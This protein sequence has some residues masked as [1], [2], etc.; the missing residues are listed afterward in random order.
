M[1]LALS[2]E[3]PARWPVMEGDYSVGD[4]TSSVAVCTLADAD[5]PGELK[6]AG[7]LARVAIVGTL[8]TENLGVERVVRNVVANPAI[9][10]LVLCGRDSRGHQAGQALLALKA[11]GLDGSLRVVGAAGPRAVLKNVTAEEVAAFR[12]RVTVVDEIGTR[13]VGGIAS[14]V[15]TC[16][17]QPRER[18]LALPPKVRQAKVVQAERQKNSEWVHDPEG[19]FVVL[20]DREGQA[21]VCEHYTEDQ[22]LNEVIRGKHANDIANTAIKRG[23][24]SRLDHAAYLGRELAKA[25]TA[26]TLGLEYA[27]DRLM[28]AKT[29]K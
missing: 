24:L 6:S 17:A 9:R 27:Q 19:F 25:E 10:Y 16:L 1:A 26:M 15:E 2:A 23:L 20:L 29:E 4:V 12:E 14:V 7:L 3:A 5:L 28:T 11:N 18:D 8:S 22:V 13:D 21:I